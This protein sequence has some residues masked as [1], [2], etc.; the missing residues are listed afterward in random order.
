[1]FKKNFNFKKLKNSSFN[2]HLFSFHTPF[3]NEIL[4]KY[5]FVIITK[6]S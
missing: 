1:M 3:V 2:A 4:L 5:N 6:Y